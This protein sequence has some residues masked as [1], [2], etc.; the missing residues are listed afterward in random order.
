MTLYSF[1]VTERE[2]H[3]LFA[4]LSRHPYSLF[5]DSADNSHEL[6]RY[7]FIAFHPLEII[8]AKNGRISVTNKEQQLTFEGQPFEIARD[9]LDIYGIDKESKADL[10][11]FQGGLAGF[12]G[13]DLARNLEKLPEETQDNPDMPDMALGLYDQVYGYD[14]DKKAG[15]FMV[16]AEDELKARAK[17]NHFMRLVQEEH[18]IK[19]IPEGDSQWQASHTQDQYEDAVQRVINYIYAGDI[20]Q[21]NLSQ[22]FEAALPQGFDSWAHYLTLREVNAAPFAAFMNF[23]KVQL[24]SASPERFLYVKSRQVETRPIKGTQKRDDDDAVDQFYRNQLENSEKDRAENAMIVDLLRNDLSKVCEDHSI[25]VPQLCKLES[26]AKVHH[27]VSTVKGTLRADKTP[28]EL[29]EA[30][31]PGGSITGAPKIRAM[32]II[33]ELETKRRGPYCGSMGYISYDG[34]MDTNITI[35]TLVYDGE[36]VSFNVGGGIVADSKPFDEYDETMLKAEA[37]FRS[38]EVHEQEKGKSEKVSA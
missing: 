18:P 16:H 35:R 27:L 31:F 13:Y 22:R 33:E 25:E 8:E 2:P 14:H 37:I 28:I 6:G 21:A 38:F 12:F 24:S 4:P 30:C 20:F 15:Y 1:T 9:R 7:S 19:A 36:T 23:G 11:P 26:F 34:T 10:P 3:A 29:L 32:E 17:Y 5:F